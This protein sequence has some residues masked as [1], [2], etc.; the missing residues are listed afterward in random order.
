[1]V[2]CRIGIIAVAMLT[3]VAAFTACQRAGESRPSAGEDH[4][5]NATPLLVQDYLQM[6]DAAGVETTA[7][8]EEFL[9]NALRNLAAALGTLGL[10]DL[11]LQVALRVAAEHV[12]S[13]PQSAD[14][15][16]AVRASLISAAGVIEAG[17]R[18]DGSVRQSAESLRSDRPLTD[19]GPALRDFFRKSAP[20][21]RRAAAGRDGSE[22]P[23]VT[24]P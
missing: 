14:T 22:E 20:A 24:A 6:A 19:Q 17:G 16:A 4:V 7:V 15:T 9:A 10:A 5:V 13:N 11:E 2:T 8:D 1:L 21:L 18:G 12:L 23:P 3:S